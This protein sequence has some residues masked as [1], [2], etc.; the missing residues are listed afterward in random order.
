MSEAFG[1]YA[2][3]LG[4][5][6]WLTQSVRTTRDCADE[7]GVGA[8]AA[9]MQGALID[10]AA[11]VW[12]LQQWA[13]DS[14]AM[15][16][17]LRTQVTRAAPDPSLK[18]RASQLG[19]RLEAPASA[20]AAPALLPLRAASAVRPAAQAEVDKEAPGP[21]AKTGRRV[22]SARPAVCQ[23]PGCGQGLAADVHAYCFRCACAYACVQRAA[24]ACMP[25]AARGSA[26]ARVIPRPTPPQ[27]ASARCT[28]ARRRSTS[29]AAAAAASAR[30]ATPLV[31]RSQGALVDLRV[32]TRAPRARA[33]KCSTLHPLESFRGS[34]RTCAKQLA[35]KAARELRKRSAAPPAAAQQPASSD[36]SGSRSL[37]DVSTPSASAAPPEFWQFCDALLVD[38]VAPMP[39]AAA[40]AA[41]A[42]QAA[43]PASAR[44]AA[45]ALWGGSDLPAL[46]SCSLKLD[47]ADPGSLPAT[48]APALAAAWCDD[49]ALCIEAAPLPGCTL[50]HVDAL[51]SLRD[52]PHTPHASRLLRDLLAGPAGPWLRQRAVTV[53]TGGGGGAAAGPGNTAVA[54]PAGDTA[55]LPRPPQLQPLALLSTAAATMCAPGWAGPPPGCTLWLRL[56]GQVMKLRCNA[57]GAVT[58]PALDGVEG[59]AHIWLAKD[60]AAE[61]AT[62]TVL[63]TRDAAI[64]AE[65]SSAAADDVATQQLLCAIGAA[66]RPG[67]APRVLAAA[68]AEALSRGWVAVSSRLLPLLRAA[69]DAGAADADA[70]AAAR[71]TL[72]AA[73]LSGRPELVALTLSLSRDGAL[74]APHEAS[75][76][77]ATPLHLAATAGD[78]AAAAALAGASPASLVAW[79]CVRTRQGVTPADAALAAGGSAAATHG[80]LVRRLNNARVLAAELAA[81]GHDAA[82]TEQDAASAPFD[83]AALA[84]FLLRVAMPTDPAAPAAPGERARYEKERFVRH[85]L[86]ALCLPPFSV[87]VF[88]SVLRSLLMPQP[89][90]VVA[91]PA[92]GT[93]YQTW[94]MYQDVQQMFR[95]S[96]LLVVHIALILFAT[97]PRL[98]STYER[99]GVNTLRVFSIFQFIILPVAAEWRT[100]RKY[101]FSI[102]WPPIPGS[103][104]LTAITI[105]MAM[106]PMPCRDLLALLAARWLQMMLARLF[107]APVWPSTGPGQLP[108]SLFNSAVLVVVAAVL[109]VMDRR[110]FAAWRLG[111][112]TNL[113]NALLLLRKQA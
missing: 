71:R 44:A 92:V 75:G 108:A 103:F 19:A 3:A 100:R 43:A 32:L 1:A 36:P 72:H 15:V 28:C 51:V 85:R 24:Q 94:A 66:L 82:E 23:V 65:V 42:E 53:R 37:S 7:A 41:A 11:F 90:T 113:A 39:L 109:V 27:T 29:R 76:G 45:L 2:A 49:L 105:N 6:P 112:R 62:R 48:L 68:A 47:C 13:F 26:H 58:L 69:L 33:Q 91:P 55:P 110:A 46:R 31:L 56:G 22:Y 86:W 18:T 80:A 78:G 16:R 17:A 40:A 97:L 74:G 64:A 63:L 5:G 12:E 30:H 35:A 93:F 98:R 96:A 77:G 57:S 104:F 79:F 59:A 99:H 8:L 83:D 107:G 60:G 73:A 111:R 67:C 101:G 50:L 52:S 10:D 70:C 4:S 34:N 9:A 84:R 81:A 102:L 106:L 38:R 14:T 25:R 54:P 21:A 20:D 89:M 61:S 88:G 95:I 87:S